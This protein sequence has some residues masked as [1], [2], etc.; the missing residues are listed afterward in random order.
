MENLPLYICGPCAI[1]SYDLVMTV[2][3]ELVNIERELGIKIVFKSSF[4]KANRTSASSK[5]G[6]G[7][8]EGLRILEAVRE[9][10]GLKVTTD[11]HNEQHARQAGD[12]V[13]II[14]IPALLCRQTDIIEAAASK[15]AILNIKKGQFLSPSETISLYNKAKS[16]TNGPVFIT[17]RGTCFGYNNLVNDFKAI[18][19]LQLE[20]IPII[21][22]ATHS[23]Q[24]PGSELTSTGGRRDCV[25]ALA[26]GAAAVGVQGFF[27]ETHPEP[28]K[29]ISDGPNMVPT[30]KLKA[31]LKN[32]KAISDLSKSIEYEKV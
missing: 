5:R 18:Y 3:E 25:E 28:D 1:E 29:A 27:F 17:E 9:Q 20:S 21:F 2:A 7:I 24:Q 19:Q 32:I 13:D 23:V 15:N 10:H 30:G 22:D 31:I 26:R 14:Q 8:D 6:V 4:D 12:I 16:F 11:V